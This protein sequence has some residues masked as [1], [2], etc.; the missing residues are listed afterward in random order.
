MKTLDDPLKAT[1]SPVDGAVAAAVKALVVGVEAL[2]AVT[3][4]AVI[5]GFAHVIEEKGNFGRRLIIRAWAVL[6][7][8][9]EGHGERPRVVDLA[10]RLLLGVAAELMAIQVAVWHTLLFRGDQIK[11][12]V[13]EDYVLPS[14]ASGFPPFD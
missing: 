9:K 6:Q 14:F 11:S 2:V 1:I 13:L 10:Y 8:S 4:L 7:E 5:A 3:A 12:F